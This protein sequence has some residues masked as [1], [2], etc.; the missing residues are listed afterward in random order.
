MSINDTAATL[1]NG[2]NGVNGVESSEISN[3]DQNGS[4]VKA[5]LTGPGYN[6]FSSQIGI[7]KVLKDV[8][9]DP[10][11]KYFTAKQK[12]VNLRFENIKLKIG[13]KD[14][15]NGITGQVPSGMVCA[16]MG[17]SGAGKSSLLVSALA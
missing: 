16:L 15:L 3:G 6:G 4:Q 11:F 2:S 1:P 17:P 12:R 7:E 14:I 13:N 10:K 9:F 5:S 8:D